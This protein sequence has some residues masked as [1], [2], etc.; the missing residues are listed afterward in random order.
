MNR[1]DDYQTKTGHLAHFLAVERFVKRS[2]SAAQVKAM[3]HFNG[4]W[5]KIWTVRL[6]RTAEGR[7]IVWFHLDAEA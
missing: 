5:A 4:R 2:D 6:T 3:D 1:P 7:Q